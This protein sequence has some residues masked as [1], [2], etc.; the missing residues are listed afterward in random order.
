MKNSK[1]VQYISKLSTTQLGRFRLFVSSPFF[2]QHQKTVDLLE[3]IIKHQTTIEE[4]EK[5]AQRLFCE[6][7][8]P[9]LSLNNS[10]TYLMR[11]LK[12]FLA[13]QS[14]EKQQ[15]QLS[16]LTLEAAI[17]NKQ[18]KLFELESRQFEKKLSQ[19]KQQDKEWID[20]QYQLFQFLDDYEQQHGDRT[21]AVFLQK[22]LDTLDAYYFAE[23][24]RHSCHALARKNVVGSQFELNFLTTIIHQIEQEKEK[25]F[26]Y[27]PIAIYY[28]IYQVLAQPTKVIYYQQLK[29]MLPNY[30]HFFSAKEARYLYRYAENYCILNINLGQSIYTKELYEI[31]QQL[32]ITKLIFVENQLHQWDYANIVALGCRLKNFDETANFIESYKNKLP[33]KVRSNAYTYNLAFFY[34]E[35][36]QYDQALELLRDVEFTDVYYQLNAKSILLKSWFETQNWQALDYMLDTFR[37]F[38]LRNRFISKNRQKSGLNLIKYTRQLFL[39]KEKQDQIEAILFKSKIAVLQIKIESCNNVMNKKWLLNVCN[40]FTVSN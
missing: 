17:S 29:E 38:L 20:I 36:G 28:Q 35:Q 5:V 8:K 4:R 7:K 22:G 3:Y 2:N 40:Q 10:M 16:L 27:P 6:E 26:K 23:K 25:W 37:I 31:Y 30:I 18:F 12:K 14:L 33:V 15:E 39:L 1:I 9:L 13:Y 21:A 19:Q 32:L 11:L 34:F 24:L